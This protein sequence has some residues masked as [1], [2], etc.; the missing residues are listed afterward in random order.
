[1]KEMIKQIALTLSGVAILA[2]D[3]YTLHPAFMYIFGTLSV[4]TSLLMIAAIAGGVWMIRTGRV[5][6]VIEGPPP[7]KF[8]TAVSVF[9]QVGAL[10]YLLAARHFVVAT[11]LIISVSLTWLFMGAREYVRHREAGG[12]LQDD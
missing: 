1:M 4:L 11:L 9:Y 3:W 2:A 10:A 5:D 6:K 7:T 8:Q 12:E